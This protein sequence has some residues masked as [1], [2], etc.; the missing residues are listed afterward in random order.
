MIPEN[1]GKIYRF[2]MD[3]GLGFG[4]AEVYDFTDHSMFDGRF[5]FVYSR[6]DQTEK[7]KY[8]IGKIRSSTIALG[9]I[10][11][12]KFPNVRGLHAWKYLFKSDDFM[13]KEIP[14]TKYFRGFAPK[15]SN[16]DNLTEWYRRSDIET[17]IKYS[18]ARSLETRILHSSMGV[19]EQFSMMRLIELN[20]S[21]CDYYNLSEAGSRNMFIHL[22]NT[23]YP[24]EKARKL[25]KALPDKVIYNY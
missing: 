8:D 23:Y 14:E 5:I 11:L 9:P 4:F 6:I 12:Y 16:W 13:I 21:V 15:E 10:T 19:I 25:L 2:K 7:K 1:S 18:E 22:V 17:R 3:H 24:L 20:K